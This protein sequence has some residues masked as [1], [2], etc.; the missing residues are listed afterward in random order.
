MRNTSSCVGA[1]S[2]SSSSSASQ[3]CCTLWMHAVDSVAAADELVGVFVGAILAPAGAAFQQVPDLVAIA[4]AL[5]AHLGAQ[6]RMLPRD[7]VP[8]RAEKRFA[9]TTATLPTT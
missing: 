9:H 3:T 8:L 2:P 1:S 4:L 7:A 6:A 5:H